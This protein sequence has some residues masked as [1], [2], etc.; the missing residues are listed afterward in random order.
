MVHDSPFINRRKKTIEFHIQHDCAHQICLS[1]SFNNWAQDVL[2]LTNKK[3]EWK[4]EIP[5]LPKGHYYYKFFIDDQMWVEDID[6]PWRE[7]D[8]KYGWNSVLEI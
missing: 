2:L 3:G 8:G 7:P 5:L 1:G 6:N 4:I